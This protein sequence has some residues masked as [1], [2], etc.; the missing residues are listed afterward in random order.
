MD[1][2]IPEYII[3]DK[4]YISVYETE[5]AAQLAMVTSA[6][7]EADVEAAGFNCP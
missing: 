2:R 3:D 4:S 6:F 5:S 7:S 1:L